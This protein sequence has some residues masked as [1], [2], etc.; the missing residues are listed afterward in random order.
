MP[1]A[2]KDAKDDDLVFEHAE[3]HRVRESADDRA[4]NLAADARI[5]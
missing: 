2:M 5:G 1:A 3:E 4:S